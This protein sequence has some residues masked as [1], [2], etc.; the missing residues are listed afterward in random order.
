VL[1]APASVPVNRASPAGT[2]HGRP[3]CDERTR[4]GRPVP[5]RRRGLPGR[6]EREAHQAQGPVMSTASRRPAPAAA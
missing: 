4:G 6:D 2:L 3:R 1:R 5:G